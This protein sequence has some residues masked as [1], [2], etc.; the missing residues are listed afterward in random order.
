MTSTMGS[1]L[2]GLVLG[3]AQLANGSPM[4]DAVYVTQVV[5]ALTTYCP[6]PTVITHG[7]KT[8][9]IEEATTFTITDC[10]CTIT[11]MGPVPTGPPTSE[12]ATNCGNAYNT[13]RGAPDANRASCA[14]EYAGCLGY[15]PFGPDG[16]LITPT[17]CSAQISATP[18]PL[19]SPIEVAPCPAACAVS[20]DKCRGAPDANRASCAAEYAGCL[21]YSPFGPDGSLVTPTACSAAATTPAP[22]PTGAAPTAPAGNECAQKCAMVYGQCRS[23]PNANRSTCAANYAGCLGY[24]PFGADGSLVTPTACSASAPGVAQPTGTG[25]ALPSHV[26]VAG[27]ERVSFVNIATAFGACGLAALALL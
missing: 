10:P 1:L 18:V 6:G 17:A 13:C 26:V 16:S 20:Y 27:A 14:A 15:S 22:A 25:M 7:P 9:T 4:A 24:S 19:P 3:A 8:Y 23:D 11:H 12:C 2:V 5:N 21:G